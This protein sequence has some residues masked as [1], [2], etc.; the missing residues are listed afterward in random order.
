MSDI[1]AIFERFD[2]DGGGTLDEEEAKGMMKGLLESGQQAEKEIMKLEREAKI[3]RAKSNR[4][5]RHA[6]AHDPETDEQAPDDLG[7]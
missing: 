7:C 1:D 3:A 4:K 5:A 2:D 6:M